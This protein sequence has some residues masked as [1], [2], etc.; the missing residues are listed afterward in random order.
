MKQEETKETRKNEPGKD[1]RT[2]TGPARITM[3]NYPAESRPIERLLAQGP[4]A[5][6]SQE[7]LAILIHSGT[8]TQSALQ[9]A[10]HLLA[11]TSL[12][13]LQEA[14]AEELMGTS[15]IGTVKAARILAAAELARRIQRDQQVEESPCITCPQDVVDLVMEE[16]RTYDREHFRAVLLNTKNRVMAVETISIGNLN[17]SLAHPREIFKNAIRR[18]AASL[19]LLHN[20]PSGDPSPSREDLTLTK[21]LLKVSEF[22]KIKIFDHVIIGDGRYY[23]MKENNIF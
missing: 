6:N 11:G 18:S 8:R 3:R 14:T 23:S 1:E 2:P 19:I 13:K 9:L 17:S 4:R 10:T 7:L 22:L 20:H 21:E 16:M 12:R 5:L 15:G